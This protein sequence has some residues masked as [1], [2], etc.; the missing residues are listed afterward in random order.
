MCGS[1]GNRVYAPRSSYRV[2]EEVPCEFSL[3]D[4]EYLLTTVVD[5]FLLSVIRSQINV[6]NRDCNKFTSYISSHI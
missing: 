1:C 5:S 3:E 2:R 6:Y 4:L